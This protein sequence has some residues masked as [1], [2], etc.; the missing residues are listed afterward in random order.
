MDNVPSPI[1]TALLELGWLKREH[2]HNH[3]HRRREPLGE[4]PVV[5][6]DHDKALR[7]D[8]ALYHSSDSFTL[9]GN[10]RDDVRI[11]WRC[12]FVYLMGRRRRISCGDAL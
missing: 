3:K 10:P 11:R 12:R 1:E 4:E 7:Q 2:H 6:A 9:S 5:T 8:G